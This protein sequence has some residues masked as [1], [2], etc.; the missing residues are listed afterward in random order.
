M[1]NVV[2]LLFYCSALIYLGQSLLILIALKRPLQ[3]RINYEPSVSIII[4]ARNEEQN[5]PECLASLANLDY[6]PDKLEIII[7]DHDS[8]DGTY[9]LLDA[10]ARNNTQ[11]KIF[12]TKETSSG[13]SGKADAVSLGVEKSTGEIIFLTDADCKV[14]PTWLKS[15]I[16]YFTENVDVVGGFTALATESKGWKGLFEKAQ[17][18][19]WLFLQT[20][21]AGAAALGRPLTWM[22]NNLSFRRSAYNSIGGYKQV[23]F[24][25][26][27]DFAL[28]KAM[29]KKN[30]S[31]IRFVRDLKSLVLS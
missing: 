18:L 28:L 24:S 31:A 5:L 27:E 20:A 1:I 9:R 21:A 11:F 23:G 14:P 7:I 26:T 17:C 12:R 2:L 29:Y 16:P 3:R 13:L 10:F 4:A 30:R 19:D 6:P 25:V 22:G 15:L 8:Q